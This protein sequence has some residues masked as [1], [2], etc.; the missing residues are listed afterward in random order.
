MCSVG[1]RCSRACP[2]GDAVAP[3]KAPNEDAPGLGGAVNPCTVEESKTWL[4]TK[5]PDAPAMRRLEEAEW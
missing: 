5:N 2:D 1:R 3:I 4:K